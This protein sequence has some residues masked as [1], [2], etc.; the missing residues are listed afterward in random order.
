MNRDDP[1]AVVTG[2]ASGMGAAV[3]ERFVREGW[4]VVGID[5]AA[6]ALTTHE[7]ALG[8]GFRPLA[9]DVVDR[10]ALERD[11]PV[12]AAPYALRA[13][14]NAAGIYPPSTLADYSDQAYRRIFDVNVLGTLNVVAAAAPLLREAGGGAIVNFASVDAFAVSPGQLL[15]SASKQRRHRADGRGRRLDPARPR[16]RPR[17]DRRLGLAAMPRQL[18]DR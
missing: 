9:A 18:H 15:Y 10:A 3:A 8:S 13:V 4:R 12:A 5:L 14:V 17:G 1:C 7:R 6:A 2:A 11:L 16:G